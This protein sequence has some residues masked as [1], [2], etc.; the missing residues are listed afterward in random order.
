MDRVFKKNYLLSL[1]LVNIFH[2]GVFLDLS[3][4]AK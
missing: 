3:K 1:S 2:S 4:Q